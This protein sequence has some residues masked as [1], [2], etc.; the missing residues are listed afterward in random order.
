ML[1]LS[2]IV[3][4][5]SVIVEFAYNTSVY[6]NLALNERDRLQAYYMA[7]SAYSFMLLE[8]KF[9]KQFRKIVETQNLSQYL[10]GNAQ[11]PLCQQFPLSTGLI[12]TVFAGGIAGQGATTGEPEA[13]ETEADAQVEE[14]QKGTSLS[15]EKNAQD[16]L[17]FEGDF[18]AECSDEGAKINLNGFAGL[19][20][21]ATTDGTLTP[22]DQYKKFLYDFLSKASY[23]P[24]FEEADVEVGTAVDN[25][26][27]WIDPDSENNQMNGRTAGSERTSYDRL[28]LDYQPRN[29]KLMTLLEAYLIDGVSDYWFEPLEDS[30]TVY[31]EGK[32]N[33]C[34]AGEDVVTSLILRYL[35]MNPLYASIKVSDEQVE[36][37]RKA[38]SSLCSDGTVPNELGA[39]VEIEIA[40]VL[41]TEG[42]E[43]GG[44]NAEGKR[45]ADL[46]SAEPRFFSL[47]LSGQ[48]VD[49]V[50]RV[51]AVV[52]AKDADP[53]KWK[54]FYWRVQ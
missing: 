33:L 7:K 3:L 49:T 27:D 48:V 50:V 11:L 31:G 43:T 24:L 13:T 25:I 42:S 4:L 22:Y 12:R 26:A 28:Q 5:S 6:Y 51:S 47:K 23:K 36:T 53:K 1:V 40:K 16:F 2:A 34:T 30:F 18:D 15:Q 45:F 21:T 52:D 35:S 32:I 38:V 39:K 10:G 29:G 9:D 44:A 41:G 46:I 8:L 19:S 17:Q 37:M 54:L 14:L 20:R